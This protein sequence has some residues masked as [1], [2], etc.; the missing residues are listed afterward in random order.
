MLIPR[1]KT[2]VADP[3]WLHE[4]QLPGETRGAT[5]QYPCL[6]TN[7]IARFPLPPMRDDCWLFLWY[8][9]SMLDDARL[10]CRIWGFEPAGGELVWVKTTGSGLT[11]IDPIA[12]DGVVDE[13]QQQTLVDIGATKPAFGMGRTVRNCDERC[14]IARRGRPELLD[15]S[16]RSVFFAPIGEHSSKPQRFYQLVE[17][18]A[19]GPYT[20]LFA[21]RRQN[22]RWACL[23]NQVDG[24]A[25]R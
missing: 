22:W 1:C 21:R 5:N 6:S 18:M 15:H 13:E 3:P 12:A 20:E 9:T 17:K 19:P 23:G 11:V 24:R 25:V 16:V 10:V 2:L 8:V 14:L 7:D 4:D